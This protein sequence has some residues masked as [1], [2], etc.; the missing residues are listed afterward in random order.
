MSP[1]GVRIEEPSGNCT[2]KNIQSELSRVEA[3]LLLIKG[4]S[5]EIPTT[6]AAEQAII[7]GS[8]QKAVQTQGVK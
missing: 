1:K 4:K 7:E 8:G 2:P 3:D 6:P 5:K